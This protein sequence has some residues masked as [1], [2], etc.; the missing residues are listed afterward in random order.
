MQFLFWW[1]LFLKKLEENNACS[2]M[3]F[4]F[5]W[6]IFEHFN[7]RRDYF[8]QKYL[9]IQTWRMLQAPYKAKN[10]NIHSSTYLLFVINLSPFKLFNAENAVFRIA[11]A[12]HIN[13]KSK[14]RKKQPLEV[15]F[16]RETRLLE[17][18][19]NKMVRWGLQL[20]WK[21]DSGTGVFLWI[22]RNF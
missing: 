12:K 9:I 11:S 6:C 17:P 4:K 1:K 8:W 7:L 2:V 21:R 14:D 5:C 3:S 13:L 19:F 18:I 16:R 15:F 10:I 22:L 20:Y